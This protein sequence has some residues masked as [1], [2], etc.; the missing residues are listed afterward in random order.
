MPAPKQDGISTARSPVLRKPLD[1]GGVEQP[2]ILQRAR[3]GGGGGRADTGG[4]TPHNLAVVT[5]IGI[6]WIASSPPFPTSTVFFV[7]SPSVSFLVQ[8]L[9]SRRLLAAG[10]LCGG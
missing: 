3:S 8:H 6:V 1:G 10:C 9:H 4:T 2:I 7:V 5:N